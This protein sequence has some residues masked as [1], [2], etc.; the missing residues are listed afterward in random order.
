MEK[1]VIPDKCVDQI[2]VAGLKRNPAIA[3]A[4][5]C[6]NIK[7]VHFGRKFTEG[8]VHPKVGTPAT[9]VYETFGVRQVRYRK[10]GPQED[11]PLL[12]AQRRT[13]AV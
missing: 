5:A 6:Q 3:A 1:A 8:L 2:C 10:N 9:Q 12:T 7:L 4:E 11:G 13:A